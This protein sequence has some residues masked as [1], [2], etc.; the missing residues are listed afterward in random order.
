M[1]TKK[2]ST[3][4]TSVKKTV[5]KK[6][7]AKKT[8]AKKKVAAKKPSAKKSS[9]KKASPTLKEILAQLE[10][11]GTEKVRKQNRK[12]GAHDK[13]YGVKLGDLRKIAK[14]I[15]T[16]HELA[17]SLWNTENIDA[18][19]LAILIMDG[20]RLSS[21]EIDELVH[22]I[23]F[24]RI[25]DWILSYVIKVHKDRESLRQKWMSSEVP[26]AARAGW[27][28]TAERIA[29]SPEGLDMKSLLDRIEEELVQA[30]PL[31]QWTMNCA[32]V[33]IGIHVPKLRKRA[34]KIGETL[35]VYRDF[36]TSKGCTSP[37]APCWINE[38]VSRQGS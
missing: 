27:S 20:A 7:S 30:A 17:L 2:A 19:F 6:P 13:Q 24:D 34:L 33:E 10:A 26:I 21:A 35:G 28:L 4:K 36:P 9:K 14:S 1:A 12:R 29:K 32:L 16:D 22:S 3:K 25:A 23:V 31:E 8:T 5:A 11:L 37:F 15:K 18:R 38:M